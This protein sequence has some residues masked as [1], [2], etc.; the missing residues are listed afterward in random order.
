[1]LEKLRRKTDLSILF[2]V[3]FVAGVVFL[4]DSWG[5]LLMKDTVFGATRTEV[6]HT[7]MTIGGA[8]LKTACGFLFWIFLDRVFQPW[9]RIKDLYEGS[10]DA[11][12]S[13]TVRSAFVHGYYI[14]A[15][16]VVLG[17]SLGGTP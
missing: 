15:A 9:L 7:V 16:A 5:H 3:I 6:G 10:P 17:V 14:L 11:P 13:L 12:E 2:L 4:H 8:L 1:M